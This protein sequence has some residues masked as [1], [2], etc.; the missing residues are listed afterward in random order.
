MSDDND[1]SFSI[2]LSSLLVLQM[3]LAWM[4]IPLN[5]D[6]ILLLLFLIWDLV[7]FW[8]DEG[9]SLRC[10]FFDGGG[11]FS[12]ITLDF[13]LLVISFS[14][15]MILLTTTLRD[16]GTCL[17]SVLFHPSK[18]YRWI[19][20]ITGEIHPVPVNFTPMGEFHLWQVNF[21]GDRWNSPQDS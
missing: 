2:V 6:I 21:T 12:V 20:P 17:F 15:M 4:A 11:V 8:M 10:S 18:F 7:N 14:E 9:E 3:V 13:F 5:H 19:S 16:T 1:V